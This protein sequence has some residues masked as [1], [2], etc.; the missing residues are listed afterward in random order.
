M[1]ELQ[2]RLLDQEFMVQLNPPIVEE[3]KLAPVSFTGLLMYPLR[4]KVI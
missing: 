2:M 3:V 1:P 4:L